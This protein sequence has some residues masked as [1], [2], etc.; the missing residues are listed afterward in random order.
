LG[1]TG[2]SPA[3]VSKTVRRGVHLQPTMATGVQNKRLLLDKLR[4]FYDEPEHCRVW[5]DVLLSNKY[6]SLRT[7]DWLVTNYSQSKNV[8][9]PVGGNP[10]HLALEYR[11]QLKAYSKR[12]FDPFN[13]RDKIMFPIMDLRKKKHMQGKE[14]N[15]CASA[16]VPEEAARHGYGPDAK[17]IDVMTTVCLLNFLRFAM[18]AGVLEF[19]RQN[20]EEIEEHM[21]RRHRKPSKPLRRN[22]GRGDHNG[23]KLEQRR[24][25]REGMVMRRNLR[26]VMRFN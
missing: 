18:T 22:R 15:T 16:A 12:Y 5:L 8:V 20:K 1:P 11:N 4:V 9:Y 25:M 24:P 2:Q 6:P 14:L 19:A 17:T 13:R 26:I 3:T 23:G 7:I 10:F 21:A